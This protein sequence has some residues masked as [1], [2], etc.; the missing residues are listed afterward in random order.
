MFND[1]LPWQLDHHRYAVL[2]VPRSGT[3]LLESFI[4]Y[5]LSKKDSNVAALQELFSIHTVMHSTVLLENNLLKMAHQTVG[6][7][8]MQAAAKARLETIKSGDPNQALVCRAFLDTGMNALG[9]TEGIV[10]LQ[11]LN[12]KFVYINRRF[13]HKILSGLFAMESFIFNGT[14]NTKTL[15]I[16]TDQLKTFIMYRYLVEQH[17][18]KLMKLLIP[19]YHIVEYDSLVEKANSLSPVEREEAFGIY[20]EKQLPLDPYEQVENS[21]EVKKVFAEFY[22]KLQLLTDMVLT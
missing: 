4:K 5:S 3:Q 19:E 21:E 11:N 7:T 2:G 10:Y 12:F 20:K 13:D 1:N 17:N 15:T 16:D 9:F 18:L 14:K 22:P 6:I 8:N